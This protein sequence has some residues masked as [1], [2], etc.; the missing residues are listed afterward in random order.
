MF[1]KDNPFKNI[2]TVFKLKAEETYIESEIVNR[3][4]WS[5]T[6]VDRSWCL[7]KLTYIS[8]PTYD[9]AFI[10]IQKKSN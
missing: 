1:P 3:F 7:T 4:V 9:I 10:L 8:V 5:I 6:Y 2:L